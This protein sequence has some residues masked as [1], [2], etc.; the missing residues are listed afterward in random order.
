[1]IDKMKCSKR[2]MFQMK[3]DLFGISKKN[4]YSILTGGP[5]FSKPKG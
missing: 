1:M 3:F 4:S 2:A 5:R